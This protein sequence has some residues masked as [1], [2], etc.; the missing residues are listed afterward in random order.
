MDKEPLV[1]RRLPVRLVPDPKLKI[2]RFLWAGAACAKRSWE[3]VQV[4]NCGSP[5]ET[6]AGWLLLTHGVGPIRRSCL[7]AMRPD[8][9]DPTKVI[10]RLDQPPLAPMPDERT[11]HVPNVV[12]SCGGL[13]HNTTLIIP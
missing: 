11:G 5:M 3:F 7:G 13:A 4:G 1:E 8:L 12:Y 2:A 9:K 10:G 6:E